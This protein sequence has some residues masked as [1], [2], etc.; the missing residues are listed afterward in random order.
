MKANVVHSD[1]Y[2]H[3]RFVALKQQ[4][5]SSLTATKTNK[6]SYTTS[7]KYFIVTELN[8]HSSKVIYL[9]IN[10]T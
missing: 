7:A 1:E 9:W 8:S 5:D 6:L 10:E 3:Q 2:R 4:T